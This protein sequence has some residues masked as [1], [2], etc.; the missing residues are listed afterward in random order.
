MLRR[1][2]QNMMYTD[3]IKATEVEKNKW[4][5]DF[6]EFIAQVKR[7]EKAGM[8]YFNAPAVGFRK[9]WK[10]STIHVNGSIPAMSYEGYCY[11]AQYLAELRRC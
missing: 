10:E 9:S 3:G 5:F 11:V 2:H 4:T 8:R 6:S 7:Y 1:M